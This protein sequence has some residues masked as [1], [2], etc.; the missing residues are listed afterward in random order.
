[1]LGSLGLASVNTLVSAIC[2]YLVIR[3]IFFPSKNLFSWTTGVSM[4]RA[5]DLALADIS[6]EVLVTRS[7]VMELLPVGVAMMLGKSLTMAAFEY[8]PLS[9]SNTIKMTQAAF[10]V[11]LGYIWL[12]K[13]PS[14]RVLLSLIPLLFGATLTAGSDLSFNFFGF[15][16][17]FF[18]TCCSTFQNLYFKN[19]VQVAKYPLAGGSMQDNILPESRKPSKHQVIGRMVLIHMIIAFSA[20]ALSLPPAFYLEV[21]RSPTASRG[22]AQ[23]AGVQKKVDGSFVLASMQIFAGSLMTWIGSVSAY[24]F[25]ASVNTA[26]THNIAKLVQRMLRIVISVIIFHN[27]ISLTNA[28]GMMMALGGVALYSV[29][30]AID[31]RRAPKRGK[32]NSRL[33]RDARSRAQ[34]V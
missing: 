11:M 8:I 17:I 5:G 34:R 12:G 19:R 29:A 20:F 16:A 27:P 15:V 14:Q 21:V 9:L 7:R 2:D 13:L 23:G 33:P 18:A 26:L 32:N 3:F 24:I 25:L 4:K 22:A 6:R 31:R 30:S 10:T 28:V 1:M